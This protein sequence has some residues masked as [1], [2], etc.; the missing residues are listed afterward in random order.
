LPPELT[1][2]VAIYDTAEPY[3][4]SYLNISVEEG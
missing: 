1:F 4:L 3:L 2:E